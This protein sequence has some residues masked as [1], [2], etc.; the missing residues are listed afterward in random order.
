MIES[1]NKGNQMRMKTY[2]LSRM[3]IWL[4]NLLKEEACFPLCMCLGFFSFFFFSFL[5][6]KWDGFQ[7]IMGVNG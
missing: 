2:L 3:S 6:P 7:L 4:V 1:S 5:R